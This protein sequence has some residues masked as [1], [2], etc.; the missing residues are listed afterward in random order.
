[1]EKRWGKKILKNQKL[2]EI[3]GLQIYIYIKISCGFQM[4]DNNTFLV[5]YT[6]RTI[7]HV[8][9]EVAPW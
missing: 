2:Q 5:V 3:F 7:D 4:T 8:S 1:M 6:T 9:S